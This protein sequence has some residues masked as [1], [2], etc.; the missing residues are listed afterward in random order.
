MPECTED[1]CGTAMVVDVICVTILAGIRA[2]PIARWELFRQPFA[3]WTGCF[4]ACSPASVAAVYAVEV[5]RYPVVAIAA[6]ER[7]RGTLL[8]CRLPK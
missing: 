2:V 1:E 5:A 3:V 6:V 8:R 4:I 7:N